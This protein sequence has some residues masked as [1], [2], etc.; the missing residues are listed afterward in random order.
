MFG[1]YIFSHRSSRFG[2]L[3]SSFLFGRLLDGT[4]GFGFDWLGVYIQIGITIFGGCFV[5][6]F[7]D[8]SIVSDGSERFG[9][10]LDSL[11]EGE[12]FV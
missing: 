5:D 8:F 10:L 9:E 7:F 11:V 12:I 1:E 2:F 3:F 4:P 6:P